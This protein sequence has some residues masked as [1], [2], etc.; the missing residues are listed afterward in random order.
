MAFVI[1]VGGAS[2]GIVAPSGSSL[3]V[4]MTDTYTSV[5]NIISIPS[6]CIHQFRDLPIT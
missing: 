2:H 4:A 5:L 1:G 6:Q 3:E